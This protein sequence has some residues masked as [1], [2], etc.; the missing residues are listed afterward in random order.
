MLKCTTIKTQYTLFKYVLLTRNYAD[1]H[2]IYPHPWLYT[3]I[4]SIREN[5]STQYCKFKSFTNKYS[6]DKR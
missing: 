4:Y 1:M 5:Y 6:I 3:Q 2:L